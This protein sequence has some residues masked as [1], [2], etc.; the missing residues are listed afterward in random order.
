MPSP[1]PVTWLGNPTASGSIAVNS[2]PVDAA[3]SGYSA[4]LTVYG[5]GAGGISGNLCLLVSNGAGYSMLPG[6]LQ[7]VLVNNGQYQTFNWE[8]SENEFEDVLIAWVPG[9]TTAGTLGPGSWS[10]TA[11]SLSP[12]V[13]NFV[14]AVGSTI[15]PTTPIAFDVTDPNGLP[16]TILVLVIAFPNGTEEVA[17]AGGQFAPLYQG[18][19]TVQVISNG[20]AFSL[21]RS[22]GWV[23][24]VTFTPYVADEAGNVAA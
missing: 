10:I 22:S 8:E 9:S 7:S 16:F 23:A 15:E 17:Y 3:G 11:G 4:T 21:Q 20:Y 24:S 1:V 14:P 5:T 6:S 12:I 18:G 2:D 19:S 13:D